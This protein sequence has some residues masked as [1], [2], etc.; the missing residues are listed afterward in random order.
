MNPLESR[1]PQGG[2]RRQPARWRRVHVDG[3]HSW[4]E[5]FLQGNHRLKASY[6]E[7]TDCSCLGSGTWALFNDNL[8][9]A[10]LP[11]AEA[12]L[13]TSSEWS[14]TMKRAC[15]YSAIGMHGSV[16]KAEPRRAAFNATLLKYSACVRNQTFAHSYASPIYAS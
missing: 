6:K 5:G 2:L 12:L 4:T 13:N 3:D 7:I 9:V 8:D 10:N 15:F 1:S 11:G 16:L 14:R